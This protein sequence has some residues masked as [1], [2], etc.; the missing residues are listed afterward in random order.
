MDN[1]GKE[2]LEL[3]CAKIVHEAK[4][5]IAIISSIAQLI[6]LKVPEVKKTKHWNNIYVE[7]DNLTN[8]LNDF[9]KLN[10]MQNIDFSPLDLGELLADIVSRFEP[11]AIQ[12]NVTISFHLPDELFDING[13]EGKLIEA[14]SNLIKNAFEAINK[15]GFINISICKEGNFI[16]VTIIDNGSGI[17]SE[18]LPLIFKPFT[19]FK[20]EGTGLGLT[21]VDTVIKSHKGSIHID[22]EV[23]KGTKFIIKL[24]C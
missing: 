18:Q 8:L 23:G 4:N 22:S 9:N 21:I 2:N 13:N 11:V 5:P 12:R 3:A 6:E 20:E 7:L 1:N 24:P 10:H 15:D 19:T 16:V 17:S 14:F